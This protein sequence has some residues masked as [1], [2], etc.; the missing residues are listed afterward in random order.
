VSSVPGDSAVTVRSAA[1]INLSLRVG[2]PRRDGYHAIATVYQA[3][4]LF[5]H[6]TATASGRPGPAT[7]EVVADDAT[8]GSLADVPTDGRNLALRAA[9]LLA[10]RTGNAP[11]VHLRLRKTIP[12]AAGLAGGSS[13]AAAALVAC[14]ALWGTGLPRADLEAL[15]SDLG[16]DVPF[17]VAG[18]TARGSGRG[19]VVAPV[20]V[21]GRF[22][23]VLALAHGGLATPAVYAEADRLRGADV[24]EPTVPGEL[25]EALASGD[26]KTLG[27]ALTNDLQPAALSLRPELVQTLA[28]GE[29]RGALG[30]L[31]SGSGPTCAF[32]AADDAH[33][34]EISD[35][36]R[37][38]GTCRAVHL[39]EG[40]VPGARVVA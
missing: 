19:E 24:P 5:D 32:L 22:H 11:A 10:E 27:R 31:V 29:G 25:L 15:A 18:G 21:Q 7:L 13:D 36:L 9:V 23:W 39:A 1:K 2:P 20:E 3:I 4:G 37:D 8:A 17:C 38:V 40:P 34:R 16:S 14:D 28:A 35:G 6:V 26:A 33:A 12:P 30:S